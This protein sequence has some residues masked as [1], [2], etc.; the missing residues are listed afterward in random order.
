LAG[1]REVTTRC[2]ARAVSAPVL[3]TALASDA[4]GM[5]GIDLDDRGRRHAV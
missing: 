3:L 5:G 4:L 1:A 2:C